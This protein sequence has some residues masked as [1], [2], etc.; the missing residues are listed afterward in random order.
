[1]GV[2]ESVLAV[3]A[4]LLALIPLILKARKNRKDNRDALTKVESD[5]LGAGMDRVDRLQPPPQ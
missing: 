5:E 2:A 3:L 1:M 4:G